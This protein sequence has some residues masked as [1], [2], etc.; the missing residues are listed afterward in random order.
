MATV[1][2]TTLAATG[3]A[4]PDRPVLDRGP[5]QGSAVTPSED[6]RTMMLHS[7]SW[8]RSSPAPRSG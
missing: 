4:I 8:G 6:I 5:P 2:D 1:T 7:V 3:R